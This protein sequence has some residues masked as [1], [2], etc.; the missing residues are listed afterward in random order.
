MRP[1]F[2]Y[3][4]GV[5]YGLGFWSLFIALLST[6]YIC[7][8]C[9]STCCLYYFLACFLSCFFHHGA[10][11]PPLYSTSLSC[12]FTIY[13]VLCHLFVVSH[14]TCICIFIHLF[15][16]PCSP[17]YSTQRRRGARSDTSLLDAR[18]PVPL[19]SGES[20]SVLI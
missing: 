14:D 18:V 3:L 19:Y 13:H 15:L 11:F 7:I 6:V 2:L 8:L 20:A 12:F 10:P 17:F 9:I 4:S 5:I 16:L 1:S